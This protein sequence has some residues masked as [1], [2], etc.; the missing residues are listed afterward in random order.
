[1]IVAVITLSGSFTS[2]STV[3]MG[4][5]VESTPAA[6]TTEVGAWPPIINPV[7]DVAANGHLPR[8]NG[9]WPLLKLAESTPGVDAPL[10]SPGPENPCADYRFI[11]LK[12][13]LPECP[14]HSDPPVP[15]VLNGPKAALSRDNQRPVA[16]FQRPRVDSQ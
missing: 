11:P 7:S 12:H 3:E 8:Q 6:K 5:V 13:A 9:T 14:P 1:M 15:S 2:S 4:S 10:C 16:D